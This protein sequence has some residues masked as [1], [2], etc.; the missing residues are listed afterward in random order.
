MFVQL[1]D[2]RG[3]EHWVNPL[4]VRYIAPKGVD[5]CEI[6]GSFGTF[7]T[8]IRVKGSAAEVAALISSAMPDSPAW[9]TLA[10]AA[11]AEAQQAAANMIATTG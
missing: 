8:P 10:S 3:K 6:Y 7:G 11:D 4:Y 5:R 1:T 2:T 9:Q